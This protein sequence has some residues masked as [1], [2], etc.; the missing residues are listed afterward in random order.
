MDRRRALDMKKDQGIAPKHQVLDNK[1]STEKIMD[2]KTTNTTLQLVPPDDHRQN[3]AEKAIQ[4]WKHH[5]IGVISGTAAAF[6]AHI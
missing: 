1:I 4:I 6:L 2:I 3:L 5:F